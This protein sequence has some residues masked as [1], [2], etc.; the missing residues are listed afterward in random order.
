MKIDLYLLSP[1][2]EYAN[3]HMCRKHWN[4]QWRGRR[5]IK[6]ENNK[7]IRLRRESFGGLLQAPDGKIFKVDD[8]GYLLTKQYM[9]KIPKNEISKNLKLNESEIKHFINKLA[10]IGVK[11]DDT[12]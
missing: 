7:F 6:V 11:V 12:K 5:S 9:N 3:K 4:Y 10:E 8:E 1:Y 2:E